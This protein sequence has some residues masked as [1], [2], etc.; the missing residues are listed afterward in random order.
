MQLIRMKQDSVTSMPGGV[1]FVAVRKLVSLG[2]GLS[3]GYAFLATASKGFCP[4]SGPILDDGSR[5]CVEVSMR[6]LPLTFIVIAALIYSAI[7]GISTRVSTIED[8]LLIVE[9]RARAMTL[10][11]VVSLLVG[12]LWFWLVPESIDYSRSW[13]VLYPFPFVLA[14]V[15]ISF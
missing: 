3:V 10:L 1:M 5:Q 6:P 2:F 7:S 4:D 8:A 14:E 12:H 9:N 13:G 11:V 15:T